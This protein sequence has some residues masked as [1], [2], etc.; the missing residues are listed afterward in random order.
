RCS[1][2][3]SSSVST[4]IVAEP[5]FIFQ[6]A[7]DQHWDF[8][9][10]L[11][12]LWIPVVVV[13]ALLQCCVGRCEAKLLSHMTYSDIEDYRDHPCIR[14]CGGAAGA[15]VCDYNFLLER[16]H[17][18][19][20][21]CWN[22]PNNGTDC[23]RPHCVA[24][25]GR[26][27]GILTANRMMPGPAILVCEGDTVRVRV[28]NKLENSEGVTL[29]WHGLHQR[30]TP[31]MDGV[32]MVT[33]CPVPA[34]S[35]F[36]YVFKADPAGTHFWHAHSGLQRADGLYGHLVVRRSPES[37]PHLGLYDWD[38]PEH[39]LVIH[40][41]WGEDVASSFAKHYHGDGSNKPDSVL[42]NGKGFF[43][44]RKT[45]E[46]SGSPREVLDV[47]R[48]SRYRFRVASNGIMNCPLKVSVDG[49]E[50]DIIASDG[51]DVEPLRVQFFNI[52]AGERFDFI[53][54]ANQSIGNYLLRVQG[55]NDCGA[56]FNDAHQTAILHYENATFDP[57][58]W[59]PPPSLNGRVRVSDYSFPLLSPFSLRIWFCVHDDDPSL[60]ETP[61]RKIVLAMDFRMV[62]NPRFHDQ[63]LYSIQDVRKKCM[64]VCVCINDI[65][66]LFPSSPALTQLR[67]TPQA[68]FCNRESLTDRNCSA[69]LCECVHHYHVTLGDVVELFLVDQGHIFDIANHPTHLH[70]HGFR[71][72]AMDKVGSLSLSVYADELTALDERGGIARNL[73]RPPRKDTVTI[74]DGGYTVVR[75]HADNPGMWLLH[76]HVEYHVE[77]GMAVLLQVGDVTQ[78]PA[79]P[80]KFPT[81][82][83]WPPTETDGS[84]DHLTLTLSRSGNVEGV[85][86]SGAKIGAPK[87][88]GYMVC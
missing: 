34:H 8:L 66:F 28:H 70:G 31:H 46:N 14:P 17:T 51:Y 54:T 10:R 12:M 13:V 43:L 9:T 4:V 40:D 2:S 49:H 73:H 88:L 26:S 5:T 30:H 15:M 7:L 62:N 85:G 38:L 33:Q 61:D 47:S 81:C 82:G 1:S 67:D 21:A 63:D 41:W 50:I 78:F 58:Y 69:D 59:V 42:I 60:R 32:A 36:T 87:L 74:P 27:R 23:A 24:G 44:N 19:S 48:G 45:G 37:E 22:C 72:V 16:Y 11:K 20:R 56:L 71:V 35:A 79:P 86:D 52:F 77:I 57:L 3:I 53:L 68:A 25:D 84:D 64:C 80:A 83:D 65:S 75:F 6:S 55:E 39:T 29:H 76:C 18:L